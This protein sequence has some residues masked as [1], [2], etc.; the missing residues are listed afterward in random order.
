M[1]ETPDILIKFIFL[2]SLLQAITTTK[3]HLSCCHLASE[4]FERFLI[5]GLEVSSGESSHLLFTLL[6]ESEDLKETMETVL[7]KRDVS[8]FVFPA[9]PCCNYSSPVSI[10][11][12]T[13]DQFPLLNCSEIISSC[14]NHPSS[15]QWSVI[16][17]SLGCTGDPIGDY[18][19]LYN[20]IPIGRVCNDVTIVCI[21]K[22]GVELT[23]K[24]FTLEVQSPPEQI[25]DCNARF[26]SRVK[27]T[28]FAWNKPN[29]DGG[30][31]VKYEVTVYLNGG[32]NTTDLKNE[33]DNFAF[34]KGKRNDSLRFS[35]SAINALG[36]GSP[37]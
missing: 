34:A 21:A 33:N 23:R 10:N 7:K 5:C 22:I 27:G 8:E 14:G 24:F 11:H 32:L 18:N 15:V 25:R 28:R 26:I 13:T 9:S 30:F 3:M 29:E 37:N 36:S 20:T 2:G 4:L 12:N 1:Q 35:V 16:S 6:E 31:P 17:S 19:D